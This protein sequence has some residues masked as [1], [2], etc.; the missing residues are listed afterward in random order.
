[1]NLRAWLI[2]SCRISRE[3]VVGVGPL[4]EPLLGNVVTVYTGKCRLIEKQEMVVTDSTHLGTYVTT[5]TLVLPPEADVR[6]RDKVE[7]I[8]L[9]DQS[10]VD[11]VFIVGTGGV[12]SRRFTHREHHKVVS[13][14]RNP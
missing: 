4:G 6:E 3:S 2:H 14:E 9:E 13:L 12:V 8:R 5:Y 11:R 10:V 7:E 1:M